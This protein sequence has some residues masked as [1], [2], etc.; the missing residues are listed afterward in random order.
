MKFRTVVELR[1]PTAT[2]VQVPL[3]I[4][5]AL[6]GG[7]H[8]PVL[9]TINGFT[10]RSSI[11]FY[12]GE[13]VLG[14]SAEN[15]AAT[16]VKPGDEIEVEVVLDTAVREVEVP[17][18]LSTALD[19]NPAA[20]QFFESLSYSNKRRFVIPIN[21]AKSPETRQRRIEKTV[22]QMAERRL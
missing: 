5:E 7:K 19:A 10:Y 18:D 14:I 1:G 12:R 16:G 11:A 17:A 22:I 2:G 15:R 6:G 4:V 8:P 3:Q 13:I 20:R 9:V 21:D